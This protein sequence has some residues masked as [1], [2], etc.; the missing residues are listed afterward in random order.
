MRSPLASWKPDC[1]IRR[2]AALRSPWYSRSSV[3][4]LKMSVASRS[5][6]TCEPSHREYLWRLAFPMWAPYREYCRCDR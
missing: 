4:S 5:K 1:I 6:P 2:R 3:I